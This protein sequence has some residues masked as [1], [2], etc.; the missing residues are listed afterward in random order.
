[1]LLVFETDEKRLAIGA[2]ITLIFERKCSEIYDD[3]GPHWTTA[4]EG[5]FQDALDPIAFLDILHNLNIINYFTI[6]EVRKAKAD[7]LRNS[8]RKKFLSPLSVDQL[9]HAAA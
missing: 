1:M 5:T 9:K 7:A 6:P 4:F 2:G 8:M 3:R